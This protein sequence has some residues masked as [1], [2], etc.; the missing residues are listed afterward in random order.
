VE[1]YEPLL[2]KWLVGVHFAKPE[3]FWHLGGQFPPF[4]EKISEKPAWHGD[5]GRKIFGVDPLQPLTTWRIIP[6]LVSG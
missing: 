4:R 1:F 2:Y 5:F 6:G 3:C